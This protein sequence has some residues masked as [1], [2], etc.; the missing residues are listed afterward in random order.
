MKERVRNEDGVECIDIKENK[1]KQS[2][3]SNIVP[4]KY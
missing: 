1:S 2:F 3:S 4:I